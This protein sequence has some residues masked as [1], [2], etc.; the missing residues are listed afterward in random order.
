MTS[1]HHYDVS[2]RYDHVITILQWRTLHHTVWTHLDIRP[3]LSIITPQVGTSM[4][5]DLYIGN[6]V[7]L[8]HIIVTFPTLTTFWWELAMNVVCGIVIYSLAVFRIKFCW[9]QIT[10]TRI[11]FWHLFIF[12][13]YYM[14][15]F[16]IHFFHFS[17]FFYLF[18]TFFM[19]TYPSCCYHCSHSDISSFSFPI[20]RSEYRHDVSILINIT[21]SLLLARLLWKQKLDH[22]WDMLSRET[23]MENNVLCNLKVRYCANWCDHK[24]I[25]R[26]IEIYQ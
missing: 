11:Y 4:A 9:Q 21:K 6:I 22:V 24:T 25:F 18:F 12:H 8:D 20:S 26:I 15:S 17:M 13:S 19:W 10:S 1:Q 23:D 7:S 14:T 16:L 2:L 5:D 3:I